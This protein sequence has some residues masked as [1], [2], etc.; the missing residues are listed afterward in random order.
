MKYNYHSF[1]RAEG[2]LRRWTLV[3]RGQLAQ[4]PLMLPRLARQQGCHGYAINYWSIWQNYTPTG[5]R[6]TTTGRVGLGLLRDYSH[7]TAHQP[8]HNY[9][10]GGLGSLTRLYCTRLPRAVGPI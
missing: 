3:E 9:G 4:R 6:D 1:F 8:G 10:Q 7:Y 2:L 5:R